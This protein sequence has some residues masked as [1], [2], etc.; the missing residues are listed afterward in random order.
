MRLISINVLTTGMV[1]GRTIWNEAGHPL[2]QK[3]VVVS[4]GII[5]RLKQLGIQYLYIEDEISSGIEIEETVSHAKRTK[6]VKQITESFNKVK[7]LNSYSASLVLDQQSKVIGELVD[8]LLN[9]VTKNE[10]ILTILT[11]TLIYDEYIYQHSFQVTLYSLAI[12]KELGYSYADLKTIGIGALLH[13][14][15]K[16]VIPTDILLKPG[17]LTDEEYETMKKHARYGFDILRNLHTVSLLVAH[18]A[19]QHHERL[20]GSGYPRGLVDYEIHPFA[21]I[22]AVADVFDA[23]TSNRVYRKK[24]LPSQGIEIIESGKG[25]MFDSRV[26]DALKRS[27][28]H[29][30]N[31]SIVLLSDGR[32]GVVAKQNIENSALPHIRIFEEN[33][34][35][36][37]STYLLSLAAEKSVLIEKVE[38]DYIVNIE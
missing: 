21:K 38:T 33:N 14:V 37:K 22:I 18:C 1:I 19:F 9:S 24:M 25:T 15:G 3:N 10:E 7:G 23:V 34:T 28:V 29:Y 31:G 8:D 17:R 35:L 27:I 2:L 26:V 5:K 11:D 30:P 36:L 13:D 6:A 32:R 20:D 4:D 16:M 12:A